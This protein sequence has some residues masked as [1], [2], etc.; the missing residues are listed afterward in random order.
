MIGPHRAVIRRSA[1]RAAA[2]LQRWEIRD[3]PPLKQWSKGRVTLLGDAAHPTSPYI[4][5]ES[6]S[7]LYG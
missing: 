4:T 7:L 2:A 5:R 1:M 3:R 6:T